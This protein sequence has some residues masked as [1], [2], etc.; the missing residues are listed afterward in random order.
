MFICFALLILYHIGNTLFF[1]CC[2][3]YSLNPDPA[4]ENGVEKKRKI[5]VWLPLG[6]MLP[7]VIICPII[8]VL[9]MMALGK[10]ESNRKF[11]NII[12]DNIN[13][14]SDSNISEEAFN[15]DSDLVD[16][17]ANALIGKAL[18]MIALNLFMFSCLFCVIP[19]EPDT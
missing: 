18:V 8:I 12:A 13:A 5:L 7:V 10:N 14:C 9:A 15:A 4:E 11:S 1:F 6:A 17:N 16:S 3:R 2:G 19:A